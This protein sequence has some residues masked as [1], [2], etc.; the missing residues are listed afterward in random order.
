MA[1]KGMWLIPP[2]SSVFTNPP[3]TPGYSV[4]RSPSCDGVFLRKGRHL[5]RFIEGLSALCQALQE[6]LEYK[7]PVFKEEGLE[8]KCPFQL[9]QSNKLCTL[10]ANP[11]ALG[12]HR[13]KIPSRRRWGSWILKVIHGIAAVVNA[14]KRLTDSPK[15]QWLNTIEA[16]VLTRSAEPTSPITQ[17]SRAAVSQPG[18]FSLAIP[19]TPAASGTSRALNQPAAF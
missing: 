3:P 19:P 7:V 11:G 15:S 12:A 9:F 17:L 16:S 2:T 14:G 5:P 13:R 4:W 8:V 10:M 6:A 18:S 1:L